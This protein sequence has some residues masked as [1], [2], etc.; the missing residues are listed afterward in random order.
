MTL[1][2]LPYFSE[3]RGFAVAYDGDAGLVA[4]VI[5]DSLATPWTI[6]HQAHLSVGFPRQESWR[7]LPFP[8]P[9]DFLDPGIEPG[10]SAL[11][12]VS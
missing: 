6:A 11:Q 9:G 10:P 1:G 4:K 2:K 7:G 3:L 12:A 8:S 5:P